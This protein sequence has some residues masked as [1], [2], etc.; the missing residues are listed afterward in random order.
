MAKA[1]V[2]DG[3]LYVE[4]PFDMEG[5]LTASRKNLL[6]STTEA[7][8]PDALSIQMN[9]TKV[10][11]QLNAWSIRVAKTEAKAEPKKVE[12]KVEVTK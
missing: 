9:G 6:H 11:V 5:K 2:K 1:Y 12:K 8:T 3:N 4:T 10:M 7:G